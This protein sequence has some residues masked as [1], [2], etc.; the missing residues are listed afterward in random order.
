[1]TNLTKEGVEIEI[2]VRAINKTTVGELM[3]FS[4]ENGLNEK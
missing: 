4:K 1:M 2:N 3:S